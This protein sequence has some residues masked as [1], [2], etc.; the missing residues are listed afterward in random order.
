MATTPQD[1]N[2]ERN[3]RGVSTGRRGEDIAARYLVKHGC[4]VL[5]RNWRANPGEVDI[6]AR[7]PPPSGTPGEDELVFVEVRTRHGRPGLAEESISPHKATSMVL[8]AYAYMD[9]HTMDPEATPWRVDLIAIAM[10]G[11][12]ITSI[13]WVKNAIGEEML[14]R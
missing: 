2:A 9:A 12:T 13:N 6:V 3:R 5:A 7:C 14:D 11:S 8:A 10:H 1:E 4:T